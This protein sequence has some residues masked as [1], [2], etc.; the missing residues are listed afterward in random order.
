MVAEF[1]ISSTTRSRSSRNMRARIGCPRDLRKAITFLQSAARLVGAE[2]KGNGDE[3]DVDGEGKVV[4][5]QSVR[6]IAGV[7]PESTVEALVKAMQGGGKGGLYEKIADVVEEL[8]A[9]GWSATQVVTQLYDK[10]VLSETIPD[11]QKNKIVMAFSEADK[12]LIDGSDEH[13]TILDLSLQ[14]AGALAGR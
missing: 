8:V 3:M 12:R 1:S 10:I 5:I 13:L 4:T 11:S 2:G 14:I 6:E 9:E 7:V